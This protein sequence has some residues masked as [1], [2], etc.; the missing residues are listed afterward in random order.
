[1]G[2]NQCIAAGRSAF[3]ASAV[4]ARFQ[5]YVDGCAFREPAG[6]F[7]CQHLRVF[8]S[9][10]T[11]KAPT[12]N[13]SI[14]HDNSAHERVRLYLT[15]AFGS[16][17]DCKVEKIQIVFVATRFASASVWHYVFFA[18]ISDVGN[19]GNQPAIAVDWRMPASPSVIVH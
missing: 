11:V 16:E 6:F 8:H 18:S 2:G 15:F 7:K 12:N 19:E 9:F 17:G 5:I 14:F 3:T 1:L 10:I 4:T 13:D